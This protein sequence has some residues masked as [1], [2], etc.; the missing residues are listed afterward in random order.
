MLS[1]APDR[2]TRSAR[3]PHIAR[4]IAAVAFLLAAWCLP[5]GAQDQQPNNLPRWP[6]GGTVD[7]AYVRTAEAT[8]GAV[9]LFHPTEVEGVGAEMM[10]SSR[11]QE[12]VFRAGGQLADGVYEFDVPV[13]STIESAYFFVSLQCL[14]IADIMRPSGDELRSDAADVEYHQFEAIRL[15]TVNEPSPGL[16][17]VST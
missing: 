11:H 14:Q 9:L 8:G 16:W 15:F 7:P 17:K 6:C 1:L 13:D 5:A 4:I 10:A 3:F 12:T 2:P